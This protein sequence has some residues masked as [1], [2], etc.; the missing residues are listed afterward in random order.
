MK[1]P[2]AITVGA[3]SPYASL[4]DL[5]DAARAKPDQLTYA[6]P[7][8]GTD[9]HLQL[10]LLQAAT[11]IRMTHVVF[12]GDPQLRTALLGRQVDSMGLNLGAV[13]QAPEGVRMLSQAGAQ[14]S[15][16]RPDV[17]TLKELGFPVE[18]AAERGVVA[19]AGPAAGGAVLRSSVAPVSTPASSGSSWPPCGGTG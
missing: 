3:A 18:M 1:D 14:R 17:P 11:G 7:G 12:Q 8:V 4:A 6:S 15:R 5:L 16:F 13:T 19:P 2:S 10:V 9:D